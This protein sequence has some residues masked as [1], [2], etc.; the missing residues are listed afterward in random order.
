[1]LHELMRQLT[2]RLRYMG[3]EPLQDE[4]GHFSKLFKLQGE[5][6]AINRARDSATSSPIG[7]ALTEGSRKA[8]R[9]FIRPSGDRG[10]PTAGSFQ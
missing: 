5:L 10:A 7:A 4:G 2:E 1:M 6:F 9:S 3:V 8:I